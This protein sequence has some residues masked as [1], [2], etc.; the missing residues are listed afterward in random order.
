MTGPEVE[1]FLNKEKADGG[2]LIGTGAAENGV[3]RVSVAVPADLPVGKY[4]VIAHVVAN[5]RYAESWSDPEIEVFAGTQI[6]L[7]GPGEVVVGDAAQFGG[8]ITTDG[9]APIAGAVMT[10]RVEN[11]NASVT[12]GPNGVFST[13]VTFDQAGRHE[14]TIDFPGTDL[15]LPRQASLNVEARNAVVLAASWPLALN[16]NDALEVT[17]SLR[18]RSGGGLAGRPVRIAIEGTTVSGTLTTGS[19]GSFKWAQAFSDPGKRRL[20]VSHDRTDLLESATFVGDFVVDAASTPSGP[21]VMLI[22]GIA[23][24]LAAGAAAGWAGRG[25]LRRRNGPVS[26]P[27]MQ[28]EAPAAGSAVQEVPLLEAA[29]KISVAA[30]AIAADLPPVWGIGDPLE[31]VATVTS[32]SGSPLEAREVGFG[33]QEIERQ[34]AATGPDGD[35]RGSIVFAAA[36]EKVVTASTREA[37]SR[38]A[39]AELR[40]LIVDYRQEVVR[41]FNDFLDR[42]RK[43][44]GIAASMTPRGA[45]AVLV[46]R[47]LISD[48]AALDALVTAFEEADYSEHP[49]AR[50]H[51]ERAYRAW[52][53]LTATAVKPEVAI[54]PST[55]RI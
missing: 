23:A 14:L 26:A 40:L 18:L 7:R 41:L 11:K 4:Q 20:T 37:G 12:S 33:A 54:A 48:Q 1:I 19:D 34:S 25:Y 45:E 17:G 3:F 38:P 43:S 16:P 24:G 55:S 6:R 29:T 32:A 44:A 42:H 9:G 39:T 27:G 22:A 30:P 15:N 31:V 46:A 51:Y 50:Y 49:I 2:L 53:G 8:T 5:D 36:G 35:A 52:K 47:S 10:V 13:L 21:N 28:G